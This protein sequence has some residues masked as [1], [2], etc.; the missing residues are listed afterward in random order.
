MHARTDQC[1]DH[2]LPGG[3]KNDPLFEHIRGVKWAR[4]LLV[5]ANPTVAQELSDRVTLP[6]VPRE[7]IRV[8]NEGALCSLFSVVCDISSG[9]P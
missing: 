8:V 7:N 4:V 9:H 3:D 2:L 1:G 5:E 6:L